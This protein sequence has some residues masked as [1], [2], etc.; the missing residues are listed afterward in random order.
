RCVAPP[1]NR[2]MRWAILAWGSAGGLA[3]IEIG[4]VVECAP[5]GLPLPAGEHLGT[6]RVE[7]RPVLMGEDALPLPEA[8]ELNLGE[9]QRGLSLAYVGRAQRTSGVI[10]GTV[11]DVALKSGKPRGLVVEVERLRGF[12][13]RSRV[14][15]LEP[16]MDDA[17]ARS[18]L[19]AL[20][21][22]VL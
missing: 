12:L 13:P 11:R 21:G 8:V 2:D 20:V 16:G 14:A 3:A 9:A 18:A 4:G 22:R 7:W 15:A 19:E 5:L 17:Q 1:A 6:Y 10:R